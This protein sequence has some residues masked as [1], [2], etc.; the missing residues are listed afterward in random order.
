M[1]PHHVKHEGQAHVVPPQA[2]ECGVIVRETLP[3][4]L[5]HVAQGLSQPAYVTGQRWDVLAWSEAAADLLTDFA[6]VAEEDRNTLVFMLTDPNARTRF[7]AGRAGEARR[8]VSL[9][10]ATYDLWP[11]DPP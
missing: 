9:F 7:G 6:H 3:E 8:M 11:D 2:V 1:G 10:R 4:V 5:R